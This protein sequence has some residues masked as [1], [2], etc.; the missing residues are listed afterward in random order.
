M[1][2]VKFTVQHF[3]VNKQRKD[4]LMKMN[5]DNNIFEYVVVKF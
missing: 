1:V 4:L 3:V 2:I 5:P